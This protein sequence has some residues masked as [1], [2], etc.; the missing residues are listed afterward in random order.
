MPTKKKDTPRK[1]QLSSETKKKRTIQKQSKEKPSLK[2]K[3]ILTRKEKHT[4]VVFKIPSRK[5]TPIVFSLEEIRKSIK[6][7]KEKEQRK[8]QQN[9][10][11]VKTDEQPKKTTVTP[12]K[13]PT[14]ENR[15]LGAA[16]LS[17][18]LGFDT[19][20]SSTSK[21]TLPHQKIPKQFEKYYEML[22]ELRN[23]LCSGLDIHTKETLKRSS[24]DDTGDLSSYGQHL[25]DV[26]TYTFDRD[27]ALSLVSNEQDALAEVEEAIKRIIEGT[28]GICEITGEKISKERLQAVPFTRF[29]LE[30]QM[31]YEK[32]KHT[33]TNRH[34]GGV[35]IDPNED[36][37][38]EGFNNEENEEIKPC[39]SI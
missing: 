14:Q 9:K 31:E 1:K 28:Y 32:T 18:I 27:F 21:K 2:S 4:P 12:A 7:T 3:K 35:F 8:N 19:K 39:S 22:I 6:Q 37:F 11:N 38:M 17:D 33:Q 15:N 5:Q 23:H 10:T 13:K 36:A 20:K 34:T 16:T 26:A 29:S 25:A 30:G 24:K